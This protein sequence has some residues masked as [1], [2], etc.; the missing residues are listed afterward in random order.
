MFDR[1]YVI[2]DNAVLQFNSVDQSHPTRITP[3]GGL[4]IQKTEENPDDLFGLEI[5][6]ER[7][8]FEPIKIYHRS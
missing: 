5:N 2:R 4:Y 3:L 6:S 8:S 1:Y 7:E